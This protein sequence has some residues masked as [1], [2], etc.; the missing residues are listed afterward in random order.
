MRGEQRSCKDG[1]YTLIE[2]IVT[3]LISACVVA[4]ATGFLVL[5]LRRYQSINQETA[6]QT[7]S[8][9][10]EFF[11]TE[12]FQEAS[13]FEEIDA[14]EFPAGGGISSAVAVTRDG[15]EY[16]VVHSGTQLWYAE[17]AGAS[18]EEQLA[19]AAALPKSEKFL[20]DYVVSFDLIPGNAT[21]E[22]IVAGDGWLKIETLFSVGTKQYVSNVMIALRNGKQN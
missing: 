17:A 3:V 20:A 6:L 22:E 8:Q 15:R 21:F 2:L 9:L 13:A 7:E 19:A 10:T 1:G 11:L 5:G 12:L 18:R 4:A 14:A 16:L